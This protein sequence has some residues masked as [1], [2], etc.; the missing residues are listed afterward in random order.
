MGGYAPPSA[1]GEG[2]KVEQ[3]DG[4]S[5]TEI[6]ETS[7]NK[8]GRGGSGTVSRAI[9]FGGQT[10]P[11]NLTEMWNASSWS[12]I[13]DLSAGRYL[14]GSGSLGAVASFQSNGEEP[15]D[16]VKFEEFEADAALSTVT[17]S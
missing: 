16:S 4:T 14:A 15:G 1:P 3:W 13:A 6:A 12:E 11:Q 10:S 8:R 7:T 9:V 17:V 5:W 2:L